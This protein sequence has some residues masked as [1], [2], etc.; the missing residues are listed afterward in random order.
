VKNLLTQQ[1]LASVTYYWME[2]RDDLT[3]KWLAGHT[4]QHGGVDKVGWAKFLMRL[5][6]TE[7]EELVVRRVTQKPRGGSGNNP[8]LASNRHA[9]EYT[10]LIEPLAIAKKVMTVREQIAAEWSADLDL[11]EAENHELMRHHDDTVSLVKEA[12]ERARQMVFDHDPYGSNNTP[13]RGKNYR[14]LLELVTATAIRRYESEMRVRG[15]R[16]KLNWL[17]KFL[18]RHGTDNKGNALLE[19]MLQGTMVMINDPRRDKPRVIE[20]TE[21]AQSIMRLRLAVAKELAA[22]LAGTAD[23]HVEMRRAL[24]E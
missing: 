5:M 8:Y 6:R 11:V 12:A 4:E 17:E 9:M 21:V 3:P 1:S 22:T 15:D 23:E 14:Q 24:L 7:P 2:F 19:A 10:V 20:P 16:Y 18:H 13:Y